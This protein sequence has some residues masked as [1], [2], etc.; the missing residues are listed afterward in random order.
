[1]SYLVRKFEDYVLYSPIFELA[2]QRRICIDKIRG[3]SLIL[4]YHILKVKLM[5]D[6]DIDHWKKEILGFILNIYDLRFKPNSKKFNIED[7]I[8]WL[9]VEPFCDAESS[10]YKKVYNI[11]E[12]YI[13]SIENRIKIDYDKDVEISME[14]M[15]ECKN[16]IIKI[17]EYISNS[18]FDK[19][20]KLINDL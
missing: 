9:F 11:R 20:K 13:K 16:I 14:L 17:S 8:E 19:I 1:M 2:F 4:F 12:E 15:E 5:K 10:A 3:I 6:G 18:E 7:Y